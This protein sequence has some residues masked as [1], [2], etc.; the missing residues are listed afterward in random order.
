[1]ITPDFAPQQLKQ[2]KAWEYAV[3]FLFGGVITVGTGLVAKAW[4]PMIAGLFLAFP[5][6]LPASITLVKQ[7]DGRE[8]AVEDARGAR[9]GSVGLT[10]FAL[11]VLV[12]AGN[13]PAPLVLACGA[14]AW[15]VVD[16]GLWFL[17]YGSASA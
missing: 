6:I 9:L 1:V 13:L 10:A 15:L 5:A 7:H 14:A 11:V 16:L 12:T 4:G 17:R 3:R 2:T 8:K